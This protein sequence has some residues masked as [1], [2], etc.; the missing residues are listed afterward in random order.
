M[1][2]ALAVA[3]TLWVIENQWF[4][5][6]SLEARSH[7]GAR[8]PPVQCAA[9]PQRH[10]DEVGRDGRRWP[11]QRRQLAPVS[12]GK[13]DRRTVGSA[14]GRTSGSG[15]A[16]NRLAEARGPAEVPVG[17]LAR[18]TA[19]PSGSGRGRSAGRRGAPRSPARSA[20]TGT[21]PTVRPAVVA[22]GQ[23]DVAPDQPARAAR[24]RRGRAGSSGCPRK[25]IVGPGRTTRHASS[26]TSTAH[27]WVAKLVRAG[28][29]RVADWPV[30]TARVPAR[31]VISTR[32]PSPSIRPGREVDQVEQRRRLVVED[33]RGHQ[34]DRDLLVAGPQARLVAVADQ[35]DARA[36]DPAG[37]VLGGVEMPRN[38]GGVRSSSRVMRAA[39]APTGSPPRPLP[40]AG[41]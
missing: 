20:R 37:L 23:P 2:R 9:D 41:G 21:A 1:N 35:L 24:A 26:S 40:S 3:F 14:S 30:T 18:P 17:L 7:G 5:A 4:G 13:T 36:A 16:T 39:R 34:A 8:A 22:A 29:T 33:E 10:A 11:H 19:R 6:R 12:S 28:W 25:G 38:S 32:W 15:P 27:C 31:A